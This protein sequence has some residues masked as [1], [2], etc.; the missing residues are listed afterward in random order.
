MMHR[1][2]GTRIGA[3]LV[4]LA[5]VAL[6][7]A[8][9]GDSEVSTTAA[10][11]AREDADIRPNANDVYFM[12][13]AGTEAVEA[14]VTDTLPLKIFLYNKKTGL[15]AAAQDIHFEITSAL[16]GTTLSAKNARTDDQ[17]AAAVDLRSGAQEGVVKVVADHPS[18]NGVEFTVTV[19]P[20]A[21]GS[22]EVKLEH[23][24]PSLMP[25]D[26]VEVRVYRN[27]EF[28]C[29]EFRPLFAQPDPLTMQ[30]AATL[31][32]RPRFETLSANTRYTI[33]ARARGPQ[34]QLAAAACEE[35]VSLEESGSRTVQLVLQM[36]PLNPVGRYLMTSNW[37]FTDALSESGAVGATVVRVLNVFED[38]GKALYD[39]AMGLLKNFIGI[40]GWAIDQFLN[41]TGIDDMLKNGINRFVEDNQVLRKVRDAGR[42]LRTVVADLEVES[43]LTIGKINS[44]Y[45]FRGSDNWLGVNLYWRWDCPA[46]APAD[47]GKIQIV[48][49]SGGGLGA[50]GILSSEWSGRVVAYDKL[51]IDQHPLTLRYGRLIRY[52]LNDVILPRLT[53]GMAHSLSQAFAHWIGCGR[54]ATS[55]TGSD[56]KICAARNCL[57]AS[58]IE[59]FCSSAINTIFGFADLLVGNLEFDIGLKLGGEGKLLE[60]TSDGLV[61][62][63]VDGTYNG[64]LTSGENGQSSPFEATWEAVKIDQDTQNL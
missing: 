62:R 2:I 18:A 1:I 60:E 34:G 26:R 9:C 46:G 64:F 27:T 11:D 5:L 19:R 59:G 36:I 22:L 50:L 4:A 42:D 57:E 44:S 12:V 7:G 28:T 35:D 37:D 25:L 10:L 61:D 30:E 32:D 17:G 39:E 43:N 63:I 24:A 33:T 52:V 23:G 31:M 48:A 3:W 21:T 49:D 40:A 55:I 6:A 16:E 51:Q 13:P 47:C 56:G 29:T 54:L 8:G 41:L 45:E 20:L 15:A 38:P 58:R 14:N 53:G